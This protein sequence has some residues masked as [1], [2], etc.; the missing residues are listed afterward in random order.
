MNKTVITMFGL[1]H[2]QDHF[3]TAW[4]SCKRPQ[5]RDQNHA[6]VKMIKT[7]KIES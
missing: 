5:V 4:R 3:A 2:S 6:T 7:P 1:G